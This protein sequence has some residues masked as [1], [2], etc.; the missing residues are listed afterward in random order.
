MFCYTT[1]VY[2]VSVASSNRCV[3]YSRDDPQ[4]AAAHSQCSYVQ[5]Y[6][7]LTLEASESMLKTLFTDIN[8]AVENVSLAQSCADAFS[9]LYCH[10]VYERCTKASNGTVHA[11][12]DAQRLCE[13]DCYDLTSKCEL[14]WQFLTDVLSA[15]GL[16]S[17]MKNCST[18]MHNEVDTCIHPS[19]GMFGAVITTYVWMKHVHHIHCR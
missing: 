10:Q 14:Q 11:P 3:L 15:Q 2:S 7:N 17:L 6:G 8:T 13:S 9:L 4:C 5:P 12:L 19:A 18:N 1:F 16:P